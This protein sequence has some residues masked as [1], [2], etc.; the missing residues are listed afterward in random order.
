VDAGDSEPRPHPVLS[1][2]IEVLA[3][4]NDAAIRAQVFLADF[5]AR[6]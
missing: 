4:V 3:P 2:R 6:V 1:R 5:R